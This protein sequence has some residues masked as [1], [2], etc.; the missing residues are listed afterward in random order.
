MMND[1]G[2]YCSKLMR[3]NLRKEYTIMNNLN[4]NYNQIDGKIFQGQF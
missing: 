3:I 2:R 4:M 1:V